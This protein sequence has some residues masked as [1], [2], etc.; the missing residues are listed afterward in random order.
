[1]DHSS[2]NCVTRCLNVLELSMPII[3]Y[4]SMRCF[5]YHMLDSYVVLFRITKDFK[6]CLCFEFF[7][8]YLLFPP[9]YVTVL[10]HV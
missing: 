7:E 9:S 4:D 3:N 8:L 6:N 2:S 1:L 5:F 10:P